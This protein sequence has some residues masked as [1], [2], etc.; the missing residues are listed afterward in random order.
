MGALS[1]YG[2]L[3]ITAEGAGGVTEERG[4]KEELSDLKS[5]APDQLFDV[6][7]LEKP[8]LDKVKQALA[9]KGKTEAQA[10]L[11]K[12][13]R[14]KYP[15]EKAAAKR[16]PGEI[17]KA[18]ER[19]ADLE[20]NTFQWGPYPA[21]S[22]G[23][24]IDWASDPAKDI[25]W[26][27]AVYRFYW[28]SDLT[29][30]YLHTRDERYAETFIRLVN[31]WLDK[32]P[33]PATLN[34]VHPVYTYWKGYAWLDLQTGIRATNICQ[35]FR[36]FVNAEAFTPAFLA[37]LMAS[38]Y[39]H[40]QKTL[41][42]PMN[43]IHNKAVFEQRGFVNVIHTFPEFRGK[44]EWL[45]KSMGI[46]YTNLMAQV[47]A[48]GVQRE[49][50]GGYHHGVY[51]DFMEIES[52]YR[53]LGSPVPGKY[54]DRVRKMAD[55]MFYL[56][57]PELEFPMFGDTSRPASAKRENSS[58]ASSFTEA[59]KRFGDPK[60]KALVEEDWDRLPKNGS[61]AFKQ[62]GFY[63]LRNSW[64]RDQVYMALH[65]SPRGIS[66]HDQPDNGTFEL[67]AYGRWLMPDTG[68]YLYGQKNAEREWH[69]KT[70]RHATLT[71]DRKDSD[72]AGHHMIWES[73]DEQDLFCV[74]NQSHYIALL[75]RR[76]V[77]FANKSARP[78]FVL[79]DEAIGDANGKLEIHF[80]L[81]PGEIDLNKAENS[82][83]TKFDDANLL[84]RVYGKAPVALSQEKGWTS[85]QYGK[86]TERPA[87][88]AGYEGIAPFS[89]VSILVPF[90][91]TSAP[92][93][94]LLTDPASLIAGDNPVELR[95]EVD[96]KAYSVSRKI[97][98]S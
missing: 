54:M 4:E 76:T 28:A 96:G 52:R 39:D 62:A 88:S 5:L 49:W 14:T 85:D 70:A 20:K 72:T 10:E 43:K 77:W 3:G 82:F 91:G 68:Y 50:C 33:L 7:D 29:A 75:H 48:D 78:F 89:F 69:R 32:H 73:G 36:V 66:S 23:K 6:L 11:L 41:L 63:I 53:E 35:A 47:T 59:S 16:S 26:I 45:A 42:M 65:C 57:T 80:P 46:T 83:R 92:S 13:Y 18:L 17:Q 56:S 15:A 79:L 64:K 30:A 86:R 9:R 55:Y 31:D 98:D 95:V 61:T 84:V 21:A 38:L 58:V 51:R 2:G 22:Y 44:E 67:Y 71:F 27:A 34:D 60:Y 93:C 37:R 24:D 94:R 25:E 81:A 90:R 87:I 97:A 19:A 1:L 40:Q 8:G 12:Y 74:E